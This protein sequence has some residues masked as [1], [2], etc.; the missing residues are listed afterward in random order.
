MKTKKLNALK[1]NKSIVSQITGGNEITDPDID[2]DDFA[3]TKQHSMHKQCE[4]TR[5]DCYISL[6]DC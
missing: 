3:E 1:L 6:G 4:A 5:R 2:G